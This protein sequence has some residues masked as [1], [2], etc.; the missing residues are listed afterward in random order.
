MNILLIQ[1]K[2]GLDKSQKLAHYYQFL[3]HFYTYEKLTIVHHQLYN[4][5]EEVGYIST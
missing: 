2:P 3:S 1:A 5:A 4:Q